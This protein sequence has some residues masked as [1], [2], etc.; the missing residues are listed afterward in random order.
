MMSSLSSYVLV[1]VEGLEPPRLAAPEPKSGASANFAIPANCHETARPFPYGRNGA[2]P[3][4]RALLTK[5]LAG[6]ERKNTKTNMDPILQM[7]A[8][9]THSC[10]ILMEKRIGTD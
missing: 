9:L 5:A 8:A 3:Q 1:R 10:H 6:C 7:A 4:I 2:G